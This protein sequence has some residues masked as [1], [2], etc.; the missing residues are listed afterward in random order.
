M[1]ASIWSASLAGFRERVA[2]TD[3]VPAGVAVSAVTASLALAL[4][5]KVLAIAGGRKAFAGDRQRIEALIDAARRESAGLTRLADEDIRVFNS[6]MDCIRSPKTPEREQAMTAAMREAIRVPMDAA[7]S[8]VRGLDLCREASTMGV[9]GLTAA[10]LGAAA[11]L[12]S[13]AVDA[14]LLS[15]ESNLRQIPVDDPFC[16]ETNR[17]LSSLRLIVT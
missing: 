13:G 5:A 12:L 16:E 11:A 15:V 7:R 3:P 17:E 8:A 6:Y 2:G 9:T 10:D 1:E 14:M 4:L